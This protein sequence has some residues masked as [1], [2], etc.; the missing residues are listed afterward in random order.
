[1][2]AI[3]IVD[4]RETVNHAIISIAGIVDAASPSLM[5]PLYSVINL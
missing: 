1:M 4:Q 3:G 5:F 2:P